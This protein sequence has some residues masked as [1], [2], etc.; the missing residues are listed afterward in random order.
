[1]INQLTVD[2]AFAA[3]QLFVHAERQNLRHLV[4]IN[5][6][7]VWVCQQLELATADWARHPSW[8]PSKRLILD[9]RSWNA[10]VN[11]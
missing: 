9:D 8:I 4:M 3:T 10:F 5:Q 6:L 2:V 1:M 11:G 7:T